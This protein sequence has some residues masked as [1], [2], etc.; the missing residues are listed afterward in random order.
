MVPRAWRRSLPSLATR[1]RNLRARCKSAPSWASSVMGRT[2]LPKV[3]LLVSLT[4]YGYYGHCSSGCITFCG[5]TLPPRSV[6]KRSNLGSSTA[7]SSFL[8]SIEVLEDLGFY[9]WKP[10]SG[11]K[12][13]MGQVTADDIRDGLE[14]DD[15]RDD[16]VTRLALE[17]VKLPVSFRE[18]KPQRT[19]AGSFPFHGGMM[20]CL[21]VTAKRGVDLQDIDFLIGGSILAFLC[22]KGKKDA[23]YLA[24]KCPGTNIV[25]MSKHKTYEQNFGQRGFQFERLVTGQDMYGLHDLTTHEHLQLLRIGEFRV[26]VTAEVDAVDDLGRP[27]EIKSGDPRFFGIKEMLQMISSGSQLLI[28]PYTKQLEVMEILRKPIE[29]LAQQAGLEELQNMDGRIVAAFQQ[30]DASKQSMT[31]EPYSIILS[32]GPWSSSPGLDDSFEQAP[33]S[34]LEGD[35]EGEETTALSQT[36]EE[37]EDAASS[38]QPLEEADDAPTWH[39]KEDHGEEHGAEDGFWGESVTFWSKDG[40]RKGKTT[41]K[42]STLFRPDPAEAGKGPMRGPRAKSAGRAAMR[43]D[44][45]DRDAVKLRT[46]IE[47]TLTKGKVGGKAYGR[48]HA[49]GIKARGLWT[50]GDEPTPKANAR[51]ERAARVESGGSAP[52]RPRSKWRPLSSFTEGDLV[53]GRVTDFVEEGAMIDF[54]CLVQGLLPTSQI[55]FPA[56][57]GDLLVSLALDS[58]DTKEERVTLRLHDDGWEAELQNA[59]AEPGS[60]KPSP[61]KTEKGRQRRAHRTSA[62]LPPSLDRAP[63]EDAMD[64]AKEDAK[65]DVKEVVREDPK[66]DEVPRVTRSEMRGGPTAPRPNRSQRRHNSDTDEVNSGSEQ[67]IDQDKIQS[68]LTENRKAEDCGKVVAC[69]PRPIQAI[70]KGWPGNPNLPTR[71][72]ESFEASGAAKRRRLTCRAMPADGAEHEVCSKSPKKG[73]METDDLWLQLIRQT[74]DMEK[75]IRRLAG[76]DRQASVTA[77]EPSFEEKEVADSVKNV[78]NET[79][80]LASADSSHAMQGLEVFESVGVANEEATATDEKNKGATVAMAVAEHPLLL[81]AEQTPAELRRCKLA[82]QSGVR[83]IGWST[84]AFAWAVHFPKLDSQ[85]K[86]SWTSRGFAVKKFMVPGCTEAEADAAALK[87]A[88]AFRA[89]LVEK[90]ILREPKPKDPNVTSE[91]PGVQW[92]KKW[93]KWVVQIVKNNEKTHGGHFT[94]KAAAEAKALELRE[95]HG[96]QLQV[97]PVPTLANRYAGLPVF[98]PKVPCPGVKWYVREQ[99]WHAQCH[100]GGANRNFRVKPKDHSEAELERSFKAC[101]AAS[102]ELKVLMRDSTTSLAALK[103]IISLHQEVGRAAEPLLVRNIP[104][105]LEKYGSRDRETQELAEEAAETLIARLNPYSGRGDR[106]A[107]ARL[108]AAREAAA[109]LVN[110]PHGSNDPAPVAG[111]V[112]SGPG[113]FRNYTGD[114]RYMESDPLRH[115]LDVKQVAATP[116]AMGP[117]SNPSSQTSSFRTL[118]ISKANEGRQNWTRIDTF[119][120]PSGHAHEDEFGRSPQRRP[121]SRSRNEASAKSLAQDVF[122]TDLSEK[123]AELRRQIQEDT[124][125]LLQPMQHD[126]DSEISKTKEIVQTVRT[127]NLKAVEEIRRLRSMEQHKQLLQAYP[128][129]IDKDE[130]GEEAGCAGEAAGNDVGYQLGDLARRGDEEAEED[131]GGGGQA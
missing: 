38:S 95:K 71:A 26:L 58:M 88:K 123:F 46:P 125:R 50:P 78:T 4:Y 10:P 36:M 101:A 109:D 6:Q 128:T 63:R 54:G 96:L 62:S 127:D 106:T 116:F 22:E 67:E 102:L 83:D 15:I 16:P 49:A 92:K 119:L 122:I 39:E 45:Y 34:W 91:V 120:T 72:M 3:L 25:V 70:Q 48:G 14:A 32:N 124:Q 113:Q 24:Q 110:P 31:D 53:Q 99:K 82:K 7:A 11:P 85:G 115:G 121:T 27:V 111:S 47:V 129:P 51:W 131:G 94:E 64:D 52:S 44:G 87:A 80:A 79:G 35:L 97:K 28:H 37:V 43:D 90:G 13:S 56:F 74:V 130:A 57:P 61:R 65:E 86:F 77:E 105:M 21:H 30:L 68:V 1:I 73:K 114:T 17:D 12:K 108:L 98:Q 112:A 81:A 84:K 9:A 89:E 75:Y 19:S 18:L 59:Q 33:K 107:A 100:V 60:E 69:H 126:L 55:D 93:G 103:G 42:G 40:A 117:K 66:P 41:S 104:G 29:D 8:P 76:C 118:D 23:T 2:K 20:A 5:S